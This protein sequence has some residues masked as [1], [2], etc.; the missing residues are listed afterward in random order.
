[1]PATMSLEEYRESIQALGMTFTGAGRFFRV[2][3]RTVRRWAT[4]ELSIPFAVS[5]LL[6]LMLAKGLSP[7]KVLEATGFTVPEGIHDQRG[8]ARSNA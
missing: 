6:R 7:E 1:M 5:L 2:D 4:G 3:E 8:R